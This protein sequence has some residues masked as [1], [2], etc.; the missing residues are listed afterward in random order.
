MAVDRLEDQHNKRRHVLFHHR[1]AR[2]C[3]A[4]IGRD[5]SARVHTKISHRT[6][7]HSFFY[8]LC[9]GG[10]FGELASWQVSRTEPT[11]RY[12]TNLV[13]NESTQVAS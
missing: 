1:S 5:L 8:W 3:L 9:R 12:F 11:H 4:I 7:L 6:D 13:D 2:T 10:T